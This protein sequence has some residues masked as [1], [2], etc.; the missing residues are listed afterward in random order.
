[1]VDFL[2]AGHIYKLYYIIFILFTVSDNLDFNEI[3]QPDNDEIMDCAAN[4]SY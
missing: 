1:V 2:G 4:I 3:T